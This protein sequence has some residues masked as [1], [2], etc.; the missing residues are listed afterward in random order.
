MSTQ[1][2]VRAKV[3]K[4]RFHGPVTKQIYEDQFSE[5]YGDDIIA[6]PYNLKELKAIAEYSSILQ[7]CIDAYK[8]NI[9]G[10]GL[11]VEYAFDFNGADV[12]PDRKKAAESDWTRLEDFLPPPSF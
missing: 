6:P 12:T 11:D 7:Q 8:T 1:Q 9:A 3:M 2:T 4:S 10:F 5:I